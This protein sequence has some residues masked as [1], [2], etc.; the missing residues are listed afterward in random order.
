MALGKP[1]IGTGY[2]GNIDFMHSG[3][4]LLVDYDLVPLR[5]GQYPFYEGQVWADPDIQQAAEYM[6]ELIEN[7]DSARE[8]GRLARRH[9]KTN[10][11]YRAVGLKYRN[12]IQQIKS[13]Y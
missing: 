13:R 2:S 9:M 4:A 8:L 3:I 6:V 10:Y 1:V 5:Q 7:K 11:S 12:R